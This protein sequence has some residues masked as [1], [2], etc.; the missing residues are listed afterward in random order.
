MIRKIKIRELEIVGSEKQIRDRL[1][2]IFGTGSLAAELGT[3]R[4]V[5]V[6]PVPRP[7]DERDERARGDTA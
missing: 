7:P 3:V 6:D 1:R 2:Q 5:H 4:L